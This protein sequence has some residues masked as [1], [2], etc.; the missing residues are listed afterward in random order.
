MTE[1][2]L[3]HPSHSVPQHTLPQSI[4]LHLLPGL[5]GGAAYYALAPLVRAW[6]FPTLMA[7]VLSG[8]LVLVPVELGLL[9]AGS[10]REGSVSPLGAVRYRQPLPQLQY[11]LW[12]PVIFLSSAALMTVLAPVSDGL[13]ALFQW[14]P[15]SFR[16]GMGL[17]GEYSRPALTATYLAGLLAVVVI[18]PIVE[19]IYFRGY[20]LPRLPAGRRW[21]PVVHSLLFALYHTWTP[22]MVAARTIGVLP[23]IYVV[24]WK[25][26]LTVGILA[27]CL[28]N[29]IDI[30]FGLIFI[31]QMG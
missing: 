29:S 12:V 22:W 26:N 13:Q 24:R 9:Y 19:E 11:L 8:L 21:S 25:R 23:L 4:G 7:L 3:Q 20:L 27:H 18:V 6:G 14:I 15:K 1:V 31:L 17:T 5:L 2:D 10:R 16:V 30:I 28:L